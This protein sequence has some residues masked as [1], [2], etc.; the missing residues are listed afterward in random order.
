MFYSSPIFIFHWQ[1]NSVKCFHHLVSNQNSNLKWFQS[2]KHLR[3]LDMLSSQDKFWLGQSP[4]VFLVDIILSEIAHSSTSIKGL[5]NTWDGEPSLLYNLPK[6]RTESNGELT[7]AQGLSDEEGKQMI[8]GPISLG[9][10]KKGDLFQI[11]VDSFW[12]W[13]WN[14][15]NAN[16]FTIRNL[17]KINNRH[18]SFWQKLES[19]ELWHWT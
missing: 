14:S 11:E 1:P 3:M 5:F 12:K 18:F 10:Q 9:G 7:P 2:L 16:K 19:M 13:E 6:V 15:N 4:R 8:L 17:F